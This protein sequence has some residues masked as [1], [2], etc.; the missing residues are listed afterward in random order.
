MHA[1]A[2]LCRTACDW[3]VADLPGKRVVVTFGEMRGPPSGPAQ[4]VLLWPWDGDSQSDHL[5]DNH[6]SLRDG[7]V[8]Q[9]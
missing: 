9:A 4:S 2:V 1:P 6:H 3:Q 5:K 8:G 7:G